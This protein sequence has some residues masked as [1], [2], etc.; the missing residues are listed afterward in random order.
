M[1][2]GDHSRIGRTIGLAAPVADNIH[3][4]AD[5]CTSLADPAVTVDLALLQERIFILG[6]RGLRDHPEQF[7]PHRVTT[8]RRGPGD[9]GLAFGDG[10]RPHVAALYVQRR[11]RVAPQMPD[12]DPVG[13]RREPHKA[14]FGVPAVQ[15]GGQVGVATALDRGERTELLLAKQVGESFVVQWARRWS[16]SHDVINALGCPAIS[17]RRKLNAPFRPRS[18]KYAASTASCGAK[19]R[20]RHCAGNAPAGTPAR[21]PWPAR[22]PLAGP[23]RKGPLF[24]RWSPSGPAARPDRRLRHSEP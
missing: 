7:P 13:C 23:R 4:R 24:E 18:W 3:A 8:N 1:R 5:G 12:L 11:L 16:L 6:L 14:S 17:G 10:E 22:C 20:S 15:H 2:A 19:P 9:L 21:R